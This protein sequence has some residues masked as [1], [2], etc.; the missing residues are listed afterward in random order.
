MQTKP[1]EAAL[2]S[3]PINTSP[4]PEYATEKRLWQGIPGIE[5]NPN[6]R[7]WA[8]WY[9]GGK[10]EG[11]DNYVVLVTSDD[12][13]HTWSKP[14]LA[15]DP[16]ARVRAF[17]PCLWHDPHGRLWL[18]WAQSE[19]LFDGRA[20][21]WSVVTENSDRE[22]PRW[23]EPRRICN[24]VM[25]N[26][27]VVL[28]TGEW[29]L[30][31]AVWNREPLRDDMA[32]ERKSNLVCSTDN[33]RSWAIRGRAD[34]P[35]RAFDEHMVVEKRDGSLWMLVRTKYGLARPFHTTRAKP[36][37]KKVPLE[38]LVPTQDFT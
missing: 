25:M 29:C 24:G 21:V 20:G 37:Q 35:D 4:G 17:D 19:E 3:P 28:S 34:V 2:I 1:Q 8:V 10:G 38:Y 23:S 9:T 13:G 18:F 32:D 6:G 11:P 27:P 26:K 31:A 5:R 36:G 30:P 33:G 7:L 16:P 14:V 22:N 15:I 12:D